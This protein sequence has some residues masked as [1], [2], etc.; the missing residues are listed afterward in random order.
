MMPAA[1]VM[2]E[3]DE[4]HDTMADA[5]KK[6]R[7]AEELHML[8]ARERAQIM[9][10]LLRAS[11]LMKNKQKKRQEVEKKLAAEKKKV[12][13]ARQKTTITKKDVAKTKKLLIADAKCAEM[14]A[15]NQANAATSGVD[16]L[17]GVGEKTKTAS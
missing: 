13:F 3:I 14:T 5:E 6:V 8:W 9:E 12:R 10:M 17:T 4:I 2:Q 11:S 1:E 16:E 7:T 15:E